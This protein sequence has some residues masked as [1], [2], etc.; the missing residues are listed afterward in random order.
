MKICL[1][2]VLF[3]L[4]LTEMSAQELIRLKNPGFESIPGAGL[5]PDGWLNMGS[6]SETPPDTQPGFF[7]VDQKPVQGNTY[8]GLVVR[9]H[10]TWEGVGQKLDAY[11][12]K[13]SSYTFSL[14]LNRSNRYRSP[15]RGGSE[16]VSFSNPTMLK[17]WGY[18]TETGEDELLAESMPPGHSEW[19]KYE[20]LL[21]PQKG[22]YNEIDLMAYY[23]KGFEQTNG[24]L[25][26]DHCSDIV[27][28]TK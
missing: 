25:L 6:T 3:G 5:V 20:F 24:N 4:N 1:L 19:I 26:I 28:I 17:I 10:N 12:M 11:L 23:A 8:L 14:Y 16:L 7:G 13:D 15:I 9:E 27:K 2:G 21:H 22:S 18:N